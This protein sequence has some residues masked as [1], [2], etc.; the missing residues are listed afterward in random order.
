MIQRLDAN[1][2]VVNCMN[3][4]KILE[5]L[6]MLDKGKTLSTEDLKVLSSTKQL[7]LRAGDQVPI[8]LNEL[9]NLQRLDISGMD[10]TKI[11]DIIF[12]LNQLKSL[13]ISNNPIEEIPEKIKKL[14]NL[15]ELFCQGTNIDDIRSIVANLPKLH[16]LD[17]G[18]TRISTISNEIN[19][20]KELEVLSFSFGTAKTG[21]LG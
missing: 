13:N 15:R 20:L 5:L 7:R 18:R 12:S 10:F 14:V 4:R 1:K 11:P 6:L 19:K 2:I 8:S 17:L 21:V 3:G 16:I 9:K